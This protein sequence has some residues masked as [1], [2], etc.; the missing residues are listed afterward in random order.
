MEGIRVGHTAQVDAVAQLGHAIALEQERH[1]A[2]GIQPL[3]RDPRP[4]ALADGRRMSHQLPDD[5]EVSEPPT[6]PC[7][8][9][10]VLLLRR[11]NARA[12]QPSDRQIGDARFGALE[13]GDLQTRGRED[14]GRIG[15]ELAQQRGD[16]DQPADALHTGHLIATQLPGR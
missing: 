10:E 8:Q 11:G 7:E 1:A 16:F 12:Q 5:A 14:L 4:P 2:G 3:V 6:L 15:A 9:A 13:I